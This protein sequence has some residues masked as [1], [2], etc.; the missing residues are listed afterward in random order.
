MQLFW[1]VVIEAK[2]SGLSYSQENVYGLQPPLLCNH[3]IAPGS[4]FYQ[5]NG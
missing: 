5:I 2:C 3:T 1:N 4:G